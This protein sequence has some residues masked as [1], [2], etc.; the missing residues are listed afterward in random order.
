MS[1]WSRLANVFRSRGIERETD[2][3]FQ[4]HVDER[5]R[6]RT[7]EGMSREAAAAQVARQFGS[8]LR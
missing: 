2:E 7:A 5:I 6:E 8:H 1:F 3:E 4:F